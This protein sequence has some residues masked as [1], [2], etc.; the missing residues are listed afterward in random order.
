VQFRLVCLLDETVSREQTLK[1][2][3][4]GDLK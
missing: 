3:Y 4:R 2:R 1:R